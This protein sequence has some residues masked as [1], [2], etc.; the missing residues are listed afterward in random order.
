M[1]D[2]TSETVV[3]LGKEWINAGNHVGE[4]NLLNASSSDRRRQCCVGV[5]LTSLGV[6]DCVIHE[7]SFVH[8]LP[9]DA[10]PQPLRF[11][12]TGTGVANGIYHAN[13]ANAF[14][15]D[16]DRV[17]WLNSISVPHGLRFVLGEKP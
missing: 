4:S 9:L 6:P 8:D 12:V 3:Y 16:A 13:D 14:M 5:A 1:S 7:Q 11:L 17:A 2:V 15:S 10:I